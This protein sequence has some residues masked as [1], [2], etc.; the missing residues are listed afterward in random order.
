MNRL[1]LS[2]LLAFTACGSATIDPPLFPAPTEL[3]VYQLGIGLHLTWKDNSLDEDEF[4]IE[5]KSNGGFATIGSVVFDIAQF[6]DEPV[7][8]DTAYTY[9][10]R[11]MKGNVPSA[12][13]NA[14]TATAMALAG[15]GGGGGSNDAGT[16]GGGGGGASNLPP[17]CM[18]SA[19]VGSAVPYDQA[20]TFTASASDPEDGALSGAS[21]VWT[22][23]LATPPLGSGLTLNRTLP[24]P[25]VH[26]VTCRATDAQG[27]SGS[28]SV[29]VTAISPLARI[30]HP[31]DGETRAAA[32]MVPFAGDGR[33]FEDGALPDAGLVW[34][35][36]LD[37]V[38]GT[39]RTFSRQL[40]AGTN[41]ITLTVT[42]SDG[43]TGAQSISL[44]ITP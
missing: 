30:N 11:A 15:S 7:T 39:G 38:I 33:D 28:S 31:S 41:I 43:G 3:M 27:L 40:S 23:N 26:T 10:V 2:S 25:G 42:N 44:T 18:I 37:G 19:P 9:R 34:T 35:S 5:R 6:H 36:N 21:V 13:S 8:F 24:V 16:G 32:N 1:A 20:V 17:T 22:T 12:Y 14:A 4:Q 29:T